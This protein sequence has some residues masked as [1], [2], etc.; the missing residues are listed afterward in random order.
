MAVKTNPNYD[1]RYLTTSYRAGK[2][3]SKTDTVKCP[4]CA[5]LIEAW[6]K[7]KHRCFKYG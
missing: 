6:Q 3:Y 5:K 2:V 7:H 1:V 4:K